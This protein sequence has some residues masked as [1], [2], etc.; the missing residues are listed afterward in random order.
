MGLWLE[1]GSKERER[2]L[3]PQISAEQPPTDELATS[4][5]HIRLELGIHLSKEITLPAS[6]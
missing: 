2:T 6:G 4:E 1:Q 5:V 3:G